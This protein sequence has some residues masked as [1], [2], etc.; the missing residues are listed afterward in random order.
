MRA[1][2][3]QGFLEN[4]I[5]RIGSKQLVAGAVVLI[6]SIACAQSV[7]RYQ[8]VDLGDL[9]DDGDEQLESLAFGINDDNIVVGMARN[10]GGFLE[11]FIWLPWE[12]KYGIGSTSAGF[13]S[14]LDSHMWP[15]GTNIT[16]NLGQSVA[17]DINEQGWIGF[18]TPPKYGRFWTDAERTDVISTNRGPNREM[19]IW[20]L[21]KERWPELKGKPVE[22]NRLRIRGDDDNRTMVQVRVDFKHVGDRMHQ[23]HSGSNNH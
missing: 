13:N 18:C 22:V 21:I 4:K 23:V 20:W 10:S 12:S 9:S 3:T 11:A 1:L 7:P 8:I 2:L 6:G 14:T 15:L 5:M 16:N 17:Y 19:S